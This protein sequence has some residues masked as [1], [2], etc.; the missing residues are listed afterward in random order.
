[1]PDDS[2]SEITDLEKEEVMYKYYEG[3]LSNEAKEKRERKAAQQR[4]LGQYEEKRHICT[5]NHKK[6]KKV[7]TVGLKTKDDE[8]VELQLR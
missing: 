7:K 5:T 4:L 6:G 8:F 1:M 3:K 2:V